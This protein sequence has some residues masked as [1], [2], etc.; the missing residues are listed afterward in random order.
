[1]LHVITVH[2]LDDRWIEPQLRYLSRFAPSDTRV[3]AALNGIDPAHASR[4][5]FG[6]DLQGTHPEKLNRLAEIAREDS[7]PDDLVLFLDGD[8]FPIAPVTSEILGGEV[9][10]AV[11]R[12]E[13]LGE[14]QP[15]PCFCLTTMGWWFDVGADWR[16][17]YKWRA[18][19]GEMITDGG[20]NLLQLLRERDIPWRPLLRSNTWDLDPLL[21]AVY[22]DVV[23]HH[24][25]GFR[26]PVTFRVGRPSRDRVRASVSKAVIPAG[27]P[28][29]GRVERSVRYR[30]AE[31]RESKEMTEYLDET[32]Q[33]SDEVFGWIRDDDD[34]FLRFMRP[35]PAGSVEDAQT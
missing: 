17:G 25:A 7:S 16:Q 8:A 29:L 26:P 3:Y 5:H 10:A 21:Y 15:H 30:L 33:Q 2:W 19:N 22:G 27:V 28:V 9:L 14:Q 12:D 35:A 6:E 20:G 4:F 32:Q 31:R 11:R 13:N 23:Y 18:T 1:M 34:F 24:G